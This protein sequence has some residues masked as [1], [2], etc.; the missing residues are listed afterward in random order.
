MEEPDPLPALLP[1]L[2]SLQNLLYRCRFPAFWE[3]FGSDDYENLRDN[4]T[5]E[6]AGFEN[7]IRQV[8]IRAVKATFTNITSQRLGSYLNLQG[9]SICNIDPL[10]KD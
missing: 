6:V 3:S 5:V 10:Q 2:K 4:Y 1:L 9:M 8:A 7:A